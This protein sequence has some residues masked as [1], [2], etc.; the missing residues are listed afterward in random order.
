MLDHTPAR[1]PPQRRRAAFFA[2]AFRALDF[3]A[4]LFR[5]VDFFADDFFAD[6]FRAV[7]RFVD[8]FFALAR[9]VDDFLAVDFFAVDFFAVDFFA[10]E[11]LAVD[12]FAPLRF[13]DA[14]FV[15]ERFDGT[16]APFSR[17][18]DSPIAIACSRLVTV[19]PCPAL[20]RFNVPLFRRFIALST[21]L[22]AARPYLRP[23]LFRARFVA[24]MWPPRFGS[25]STRV[26]SKYWSS[27]K[28]VPERRM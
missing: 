26:A 13:A 16:F 18:S 22:P 10:V 7:D 12:F 21:D 14:R 19:P 6:D 4:V 24:A 3:R 17:A 8:D 15:D 5:P 28:P 2:D 27:A 20:P 1:L 11:R 23:P 25:H 9:F